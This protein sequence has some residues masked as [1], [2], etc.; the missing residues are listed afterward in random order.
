MKPFIEPLDKMV[1]ICILC[2]FNILYIRL[3]WLIQY[4]IEEHGAHFRE[5][6]QL[7]FIQRPKLSKICNLVQLLMCS[8][9][10]ITEVGG[11]SHM[12][13]LESDSSRKFK[14]LWFAWLNKENPSTWLGLELEGLET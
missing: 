11:L 1:C 10:S 3:L 4:D 7:S 6:K 12:T 14:D 9:D 8:Y 5:E 2:L 13:W